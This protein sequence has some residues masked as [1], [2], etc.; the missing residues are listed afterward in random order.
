MKTTKT[1]PLL[2]V[3]IVAWM[4]T[5]PTLN[6]ADPPIYVVYQSDESQPAP[7]PLQT[8]PGEIA[9]PLGDCACDHGASGVADCDG[10]CPANTTC[11]DG[12]YHADRR[13]LRRVAG[14]LHGHGTPR[15]NGVAAGVHYGMQVHP[16][17]HHAWYDIYARADYIA[18]QRA[19]VR[20]WH[21]GYYH[22]QYGAPLALMVPPTARM[23]TRWGWGVSQSTMSPIYHQFERPYPGSAGSGMPGTGT[24]SGLLP[25]PR[26]PSHTDQFGVYYIRGPW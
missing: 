2:A 5:G 4:A 8:V 15:P 25:T 7:E 19:S 22:T 24:G 14:G 16:Q 9:Q 17:D 6:A 13:I 20:S 10:H 21:A 26:W 11:A 12:S 1:L 18:Q 23:Q 3:S